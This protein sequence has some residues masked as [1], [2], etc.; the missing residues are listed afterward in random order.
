MRSTADEAWPPSWALVY[1]INPHERAGASCTVH[2][3]DRFA[4][5]D[6]G[7]HAQHVDTTQAKS[8]LRFQPRWCTRRD[9]LGLAQQGQRKLNTRPAGKRRLAWPDMR[10][11]ECEKHRASAGGLRGAREVFANIP[12]EKLWS[13]GSGLRVS[14]RHASCVFERLRLNEGM[15]VPLVLRYGND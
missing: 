2:E 7:Q 13:Q 1:M 4:V 15:L 10:A 14:R 8:A 9:G 11:S 6:V 12:A 3:A 5:I